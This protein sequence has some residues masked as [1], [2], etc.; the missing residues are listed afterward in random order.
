MLTYNLC[1][2]V[3]E[4]KIELLSKYRNSIITKKEEEEKLE[5]KR[6]TAVLD[7]TFLDFLKIFLEYGYENNNLTIK[8][9]EQKYGFSEINL[10]NFKKKD[11]IQYFNDII[12]EAQKNK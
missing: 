5:Q 9:D 11:Y 10:E 6:I 2:L 1:Q 8:I 12:E 7:L 4:K 3:L